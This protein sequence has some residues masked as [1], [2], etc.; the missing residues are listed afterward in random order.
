MPIIPSTVVIPWETAYLSEIGDYSVFEKVIYC[1][2]ASQRA[3]GFKLA[4]KLAQN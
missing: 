1:G 2:M 4:L 3:T